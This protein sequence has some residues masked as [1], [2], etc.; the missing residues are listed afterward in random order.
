VTYSEPLGP[1]PAPLHVLRGQLE[2]S[3]ERGEDFADAWPGAVTSALRGV[4]GKDLVGW[5]RAL[6]STR[7]SWQ[8]AYERRPTAKVER[9]LTLVGSERGV[10]L[11]G[12][13][14]CHKPLENPHPRRKFCSEKCRRQASYERERA[15]A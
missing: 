6:S 11:D 3:R 8:R 12:C 1:S 7:A 10:S 9:A 13:E 5:Q 14:R 15:A 4:G 2:E